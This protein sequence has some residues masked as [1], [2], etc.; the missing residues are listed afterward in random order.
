VKDEIAKARRMLE[1]ASS[2]IVT[3]HQRPDGD[4]ISSMLA[5]HLGMV[6]KGLRSLPVLF[7]RVP[8]R[9]QFL[10]GAGEI[11]HEIEGPADLLI[12]VDCADYERIGFSDEREPFSIDFNIDHHP[13]NTNFAEINFVDPGAASA[14][15][16][17]YELMPKLGVELTD[18]MRNN[19][20]TGLITDTIGFRTENVTPNTLRV[21][22][23]LLESGSALD[24]LYHRAVI[25]KDFLEVK[26]WANGLSRLA[27]EDGLLWTYLTESD[28]TSIGYSGNDD[29]DL[30]DLMT[31]VE[32][33]KIAI[34]FIEQD[35]QHVKVSF[36]S[37]GGVDVAELAGKFGGGG[38]KPAS[39]AMIKG[40]LPS[41]LERVLDAA[42]LTLSSEQPAE[43]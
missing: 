25:R 41:V 33:T 10:P 19:L 14:T 18:Q 26:Y 40:D 9:F 11:A 15:E 37:R 29:A 42:K 32:G 4:A 35:Q 39:G 7:D 1:A 36:R 27:M 2:V 30:I 34:V 20:L 13:T 16:L 21:A 38:H 17:L 6:Q 12:V 31:S 8:H 23:D 28:R 24:E 43:R 3:T 5:L 22:A